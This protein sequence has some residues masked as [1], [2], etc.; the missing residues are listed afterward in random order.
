MSDIL[1][2]MC[3]NQMFLNKNDFLG[4]CSKSKLIIALLFYDK[5]RLETSK[6][7]HIKIMLI[8]SADIFLQIMLSLGCIWFIFRVRTIVLVLDSTLK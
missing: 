2:Q 6:S 8:S 5:A 1:D 7:I 4:K 3:H